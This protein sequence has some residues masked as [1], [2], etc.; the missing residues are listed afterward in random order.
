MHRGDLTS[1]VQRR[2]QRL[3]PPFAAHYGVVPLSPPEDAVVLPPEI[4]QQ[5]WKAVEAMARLDALAGELADPYL[6]SRILTRREAVS[7][8]A[9]EG[10]N[11]TL[12]ELLAVEE[13]NDS[14]ATEAAIQVR[15][16][17]TALD[18]LLPRAAAEEHKIFSEDLIANLHRDVMR[19]NT[20]YPDKPGAMRDVVVWIGGGR[21]IAYSIYNPTPPDAIAPAL[22]DSVAYLR[23]E[24]MQAM[25]Q[26]LIAR[27]AIGHAH[28]EAVHPFRDGN[29]RVGRLL[30]P[31]MMAAEGH[32]PIYLSPYIEANKAG[33][34]AA[35]KLA[36]QRLQWPDIIGFIAR[37]I[38]G[39][40]R[41]VMATRAALKSLAQMWRVRRKFRSGSAAA[42]ALDILPHYPVLTVSRLAHRLG[43]SDTAAATA[44]QQLTS[45]GIVTQRPGRSYN[46]LYTAIEALSVINRP[47]G[48]EPILPEH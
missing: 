37:A 33:Y 11:S 8:S 31:L 24:G 46:R 10:T 34:Y 25:T 47:F 41:E 21:D 14:G 15:D 6:I 28:F 44:M 42:R 35:L 27:M 45:A 2:L 17:A 23:A 39:T 40:E 20:T 18:Q 30:L 5:H 19:G 7:S 36:Q 43:V 4:L 48:A 12:D 32:T 16:Y 38:I 26:S 13:T 1:A 29:G 22:Q 3:P 9:I